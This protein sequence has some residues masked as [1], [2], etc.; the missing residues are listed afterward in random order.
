MKQAFLNIIGN[1]LRFA[2]SHIEIRMRKEES[3]VTVEI[4][5]D[6]IGFGENPER[7]F[8]RFYTGDQAGSGIGLAITKTIVEKHHGEIYAENLKKGGR[9]I[10]TLPLPP[11]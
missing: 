2:S 3:K 1:A 5:D 8:D 9:V 4:E 6:G 7:V 11:G 10:I